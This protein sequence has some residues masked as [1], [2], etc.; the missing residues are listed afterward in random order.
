LIV[1]LHTV[2]IHSVDQSPQKLTV[3]QPV[4]KFC[5]FM[6]HKSPYPSK[7]GPGICAFPKPEESRLLLYYIHFVMILSN[8]PR[9]G[10]QSDPLSSRIS[11]NV[12]CALPIT[13]SSNAWPTHLIFLDRNA[14]TLSAEENIRVLWSPSLWTRI[15]RMFFRD[16]RITGFLDFVHR[17]VF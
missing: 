17:P 1:G 13:S 16:L 8:T 6:E 3:P 4:N 12:L 9:L 15:Q 2:L 10:L 11:S 7:V 5:A 14:L